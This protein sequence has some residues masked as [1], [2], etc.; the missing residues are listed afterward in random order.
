MPSPISALQVKSNE[1]RSVELG[2]G[3]GLGNWVSTTYP[4]VKTTVSM[5]QP[6]SN[7]ASEP[8]ESR[9]PGVNRALPTQ[10]ADGGFEGDLDLAPIRPAINY[11]VI[12]PH[13]LAIGPGRRRAHRR[14]EWGRLSVPRG[15]QRAPRAE[16]ASPK[17]L[18][19]PPL[20]ACLGLAPPSLLAAG[21]A[22]WGNGKTC[23]G[24][25]SLAKRVAKQFA[26]RSVPRAAATAP[27]PRSLQGKREGEE[28]TEFTSP[29]PP[30]PE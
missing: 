21:E 12:I 3:D 27:A 18:E 15:P 7:G 26:V 1:D 6:L 28:V 11:S 17:P 30:L 13:N 5:T 16:R 10:D 4:S 25:V 8:C 22:V 23:V 20:T 9:I 19:R 24:G 14:T 2:H 29:P